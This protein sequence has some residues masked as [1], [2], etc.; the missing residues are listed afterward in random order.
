[1]N[2]KFIFINCSTNRGGKKAYN[3]HYA[4]DEREKLEN[5]NGVRTK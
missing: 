5:I 2:C 1:L 4:V 3:M